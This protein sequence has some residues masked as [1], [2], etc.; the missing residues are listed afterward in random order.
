MISTIQSVAL[1]NDLTLEYAEHG[2][3]EGVPVIC[4]HGV[5][6]S[7]RSFDPVLPFLPKSF[8]VFSIS[9]RGHG[10]SS[11]PLTGYRYADFADDVHRFMTALKLPSA[12]IVGHSMGAAVAQRFAIDHPSRTLG[13]VL[14]GAFL[15]VRGEPSVEEF[16]TTTLATL[17]DPIDRQIA[18][19]FQQ[20][21]L[22][23][24][25]SQAFFDM[26]VGESLKV[27]AHVWRATF[28]EFRA[29]DF[30]S[31]LVRIVSPTLMV[32]GDLD[33]YCG[34]PHWDGLRRAIPH[35][36]VRLYGGHGHAVHWEAPERF[37]RDVVSF[38]HQHCLNHAV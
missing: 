20:S 34:Q 36:Q 12:I 25:V 11:R 31:E 9:Q 21:T 17:T 16:W 3:P 30:S 24:P 37:A 1:G 14:A 19:E 15:T 38:V 32:W 4:L 35:G 23:R 5:T 6:D 2:D 33:S 8:R 13:L 27:P 22:A 7:Y 18:E 10:H 29:T 26:V 28:S